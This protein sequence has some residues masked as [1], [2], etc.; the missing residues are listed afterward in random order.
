[1]TRK[2]RPDPAASHLCKRDDSSALLKGLLNGESFQSTWAAATANSPLCRSNDGDFLVVIIAL[3]VAGAS[4]GVASLNTLSNEVYI[5]HSRGEIQPL[6]LDKCLAGTR[7]LSNCLAWE[8]EILLMFQGWTK[9]YVRA[10]TSGRIGNVARFESSPGCA[11]PA[12]REK[13]DVP[14]ETAEPTIEG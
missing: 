2:R 4:A 10:R 11:G 9:V 13:C 7:Y 6:R 14:G 5:F 1:M 3:P 8:R 12:E